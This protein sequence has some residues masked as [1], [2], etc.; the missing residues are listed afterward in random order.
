MGR[1]SVAST[2]SG[3]VGVALVVAVTVVVMA[4]IQPTHAVPLGQLSPKPNR[5]ESATAIDAPTEHD[6]R[7]YVQ[8]AEFVQRTAS[9]LQQE[10]LTRVSNRCV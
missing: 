4:T 9:L 5:G 8:W 1:K 3:V 2:L 10:Q 7:H 6:V